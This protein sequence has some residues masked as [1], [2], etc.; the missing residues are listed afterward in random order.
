MSNLHHI[1]PQ[2]FEL[3]NRLQEPRR[4]LQVVS[5][6]RQI[7]KTTMVDHAARE[8]SLPYRI[9]SADDPML[10]GAEWIDQQWQIG[11]FLAQD[12]GVKGALLALDE[13]Q[14]LPNWSESVKRLW[15][16]DTLNGVNL[17]VVIT[18]SAPLMM[19]RGLTESL[20]G[21]FELLP[22]PHWSYSEMRDAFGWSLDQFLFY[23]AYPGAAPLI[24]QPT[25]WANYI[26]DSLI[27][28]TIARD[29]LLLSRVDKPALMR[30]LFALGSSF[31]GQ[32]L[33][34]NKMLGQL[35]DAGNTTT[36]AH[37]LDLLA[38]AGMI[39]GLQQYAGNQTRRARSSPKLQVFNNALMSASC[40]MT[41]AAARKNPEFWGRIVESA[42][43]AHLVNAS[44]VGECEVFY[45]RH[46]NREVDFVV[47]AGRDIA[48]IE[49]KSGRVRH[50][51]VGLDAF[52][53]A[54]GTTRKLLVGGDGISVEEFLSRPATYWIG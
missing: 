32:I 52:A 50:A 25:R 35:L 8:S 17:K 44:L 5:G 23:G 51:Q 7:G 49:V 45:W 16:E 36:L 28:T 40:G 24:R 2:A 10:R 1:R 9:A 30:R 20:A 33:S 22:M 18:G 38:G 26:R 34:Y 53:K 12:A 4:F 6:A 15:D 39:T 46:R 11:R 19:G 27:E 43:G 21:R 31:S 48:A 47:S 41:L 37:Y 54:H 3:L 13:V 14:K 42:I 29:V